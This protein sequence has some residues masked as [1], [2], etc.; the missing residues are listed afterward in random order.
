RNHLGSGDRPADASAGLDRR[1]G[2]AQATVR[3]R[4][5]DRLGAGAV[6]IYRLQECAGRVVDRRSVRRALRAAP[7]T[8]LEHRPALSGWTAM[9]DV[10]LSARF[11]IDYPGKP[12]TLRDIALE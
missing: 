2:E 1:C 7:T 6:S 9:R 11:S 12:G 4:A 10:L 5:G 3:S 8:G